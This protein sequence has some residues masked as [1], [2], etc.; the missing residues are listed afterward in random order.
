MPGL[1]NDFGG[2][3]EQQL[4]VSCKYKTYKEEILTQIHIEEYELALIKA[5]MYL[6]SPRIKAIKATEMAPILY[7]YGINEGDP[8]KLGHIVSVILYTDISAYCTEFSNT[9]RKLSS[10]E[11]LNSVKKRNSSFW[12]QSKHFREMIECFG[13]CG[14]EDMVQD[15]LDAESG[16]FFTGLDVILAVPE[17]SIRLC[18]PTSTSKQISVSLN[19]SKNTGMIIELNNPKEDVSANIVPFMDVSWI[20][21]FPDEDERIFVG[22]FF[23]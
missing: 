18:S 7:K 2:Y 6:K 22:M 19:F 20:S 9:F 5:R 23:I 17:F 10:L 3:T 4:Y 14:D 11:S 21:R 15:A 12:F 16:P 8:I 13:T 1:E